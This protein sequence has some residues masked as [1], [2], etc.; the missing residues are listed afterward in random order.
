[1][2]AEKDTQEDIQDKKKQDI[3]V[4]IVYGLMFGTL[5]G[6]VFGDIAKG[7]IIGISLG[8]VVGAIANSRNKT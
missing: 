8:I 1:M 4:W 6:I 3:G 2:N 5:A 7:M